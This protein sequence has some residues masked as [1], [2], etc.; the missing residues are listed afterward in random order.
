MDKENLKRGDRSPIVLTDSEQDDFTT[1]TSKKP[2]F[3]TPTAI[4]RK[5]E[6]ALLL[7]AQRKAER[8]RLK[9]ERELLKQ[10]KE[11]Q[12]E[13]ERRK[14]EEERERQKEEKRQRLETIRRQKEADKEAKRKIDEAKKH[15]EQEAKR[16]KEAK[17]KAD[18]EARL[19]KRMNKAKE[20]EE[21]RRKKEKEEE[22]KRKQ[23]QMFCGFFVKVTK[24]RRTL[25]WGTDKFKPYEIKEG[26]VLAPILRRPPLSPDVYEN[27]LKMEDENVNYLNNLPRRENIVKDPLRAKLFQFCES[28]RPPY[29]G[30]WR[31]RSSLITGRRPWFKAVNQVDYD[32]DSENEWEP[33]PSEGEDCK[34][35]KESAK[36][37]EYQNDEFLMDHGYL[38]SNEGSGDE[39][40]DVNGVRQH[41]R[42]AGEFTTDNK[43]KDLRK[44][45]KELKIKFYGV[46]YK[47]PRSNTIS[48]ELY[49]HVQKGFIFRYGAN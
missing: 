32:R 46:S 14:K 24:E 31:H 40:E 18:E 17:K 20:D 30:T 22:R 1:S 26:F 13:E 16:L 15:A 42:R 7:S 8:E 47:M 34:S 6:E 29:Y 2:K 10:E 49:K 3:A 44:K 36:G 41:T 38:S 12:K 37:E 45:R 43:R 25:E 23:S 35:E 48:L 21:K 19:I 39:V 5:R 28:E 11:R 4:Q 33:E 27:L 9:L